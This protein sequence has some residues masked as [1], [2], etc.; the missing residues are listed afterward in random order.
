MQI[1][2]TILSQIS[3]AYGFSASN[4]VRNFF[5]HL[6]PNSYVQATSSEAYHGWAMGLLDGLEMMLRM[7]GEDKLTSMRVRDYLWSMWPQLGNEG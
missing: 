6:A 1:S 5:C 2:P 7:Q 3:H 4:N